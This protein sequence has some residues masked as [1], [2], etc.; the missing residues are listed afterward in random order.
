MQKVR[1]REIA[2]LSALSDRDIDASDIPERSD[3]NKAQ[4]GKFYR[5]IK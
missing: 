5:P 2:R 1:R 4:I 3:W